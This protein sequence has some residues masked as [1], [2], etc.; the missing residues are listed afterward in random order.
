MSTDSRVRPS[1]PGLA[2]PRQEVRAGSRYT[3]FR[4][5]S[6]MVLERALVLSRSAVGYSF[7]YWHRVYMDSIFTVFLLLGPSHLASCSPLFR[8]DVSL[9]SSL[10]LSHGEPWR[11][12]EPNLSAVISWLKPG[13]AVTLELGH[14][15]VAHL[16][17]R[18]IYICLDIV[19][20]GYSL[21]PFSTRARTEIIDT[22]PRVF[23]LFQ[24]FTDQLYTCHNLRASIA[25]KY[26]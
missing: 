3:I 19:D 24:L 21:L 25:K 1:N 18:H 8:Y 9:F 4:S 14:L 23:F 15:V 5:V 17:S 2:S 6:D 16:S 10:S 20:V 7:Q 12:L 13:P 22:G 26:L 11:G